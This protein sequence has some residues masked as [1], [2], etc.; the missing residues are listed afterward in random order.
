MTSSYIDAEDYPS[1][2]ILCDPSHI[3]VE[4]LKR[5][6]MCWYDMDQDGRGLRFSGAARKGSRKNKGKGKKKVKPSYEEVSDSPPA[7]PPPSCRRQS[8]HCC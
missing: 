4:D 8:C 7:P 1:E 5:L 6:W 3:G 2:V